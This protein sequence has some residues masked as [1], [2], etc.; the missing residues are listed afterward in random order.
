MHCIL[1]NVYFILS[2]VCFWGGE[3]KKSNSF[4]ISGIFF[5][6]F[7]CGILLFIFVLFFIEG[8]LETVVYITSNNKNATNKKKKKDEK[9]RMRRTQKLVFFCFSGW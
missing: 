7:S 8:I 5:F 1:T 2:C 3:K 9:T 4:S 6:L